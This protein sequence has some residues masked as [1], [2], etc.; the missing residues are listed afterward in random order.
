MLLI[1]LRSSPPSCVLRRALLPCVTQLVPVANGVLKRFASSSSRD[2]E[3]VIILGAAGRDFHDFIT[4]WSKRPDVHVTA[5]TGQQIPGIDNRTFPAS[6]CNNHLNGNKY[7]AGIK[8]YP[9]A[10]LEHLIHL[11]DADTCTLAYSDLSYD[12]VQ[13][14]ASRVNASGCKFLQL[15]PALTMVPSRKPVI[16]VCASRT[17]VG[18]SQTTRYVANYF[19]EKGLKVAVVRHPMPYDQEL[20]MPVQRYEKMEDMDKYHC[21]IEEREEYFRHIEEGTLLFAGTDY[22]SILKEAEKDADLIIWDGGNNDLPFFK[23]D[24]HITLVDSL[25]PTDEMHYFP[26][27]TNVRMS[28]MILITKVNELPSF[29]PADEHAKRLK[30]ISKPNTPVFYGTSVITGEAINPSTGRGLS[31]EEVKALV[32]GKRVLVIDDGPTLTHG[33]MANGVG[34]VLA[35]ELGATEI[36]D[37]RPYAQ[38]SLRKVFEKFPHLHN[39]LPAMGYDSEQ[40][41]DLEMTIKA[42][43][44][45]S[46]VIGTPSDI[47]HLMDIGKPSVVARYR[48]QIIPDHAG[49]FNLFLDSVFDRFACHPHPEHKAA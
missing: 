14:L 29:K 27:E 41:R 36:V 10:E 35:E 47:T 4:Y 24:I 21:T 9:E 45:D 44:C 34:Y 15:P 48:L 28:D 12:T 25:R 23:P 13:S 49:S 3:R 39:V 2:G 42:T 5:F 38:G 8:I 43:P 18:K 6:L 16:A 17:G 26:G 40:I 19:K 22:P 1:A 31:D 20:S 37:P 11:T 7:P 30:T 33:G 46:V 32:F